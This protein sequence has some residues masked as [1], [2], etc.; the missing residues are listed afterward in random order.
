MYMTIRKKS[1]H[2]FRKY[3][4]WGFD[5]WVL[6]LIESSGI[7]YI[8]IIELEEKKVYVIPAEAARIGCTIEVGQI[9]IPEHFFTQDT[10]GD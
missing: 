5:L 2:F 8:G 4:A 1:K 6:E 3:F 7:K 9:F 10:Y